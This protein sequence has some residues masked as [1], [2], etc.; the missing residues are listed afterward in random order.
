LQAGSMR[1]GSLQALKELQAIRDKYRTQ[2]VGKP[3]F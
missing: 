1:G 2:D 3:A